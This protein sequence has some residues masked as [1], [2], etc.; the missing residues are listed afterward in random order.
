MNKTILDISNLHLT[1][2]SG[3]S[4]ILKDISF[5]LSQWEVLSVIWKNGTGKSSLLKAI[6]WIQAIASW[7]IEKH[8]KKISYVPQ[9]IH[10]EESFPVKVEEFFKIFNTGVSKNSIIE[11]LKLFD[12]L[13]LSGRN[14]HSLSGWEF[15]KILIINA[16]LSQPELLL[17]DE[18]T[19]GIDM[20]GE[21][22]FY[23]NIALIKEKYPKIAIIL[24]SHNLH[25][26]YKN[27]TRVIC[28]HENNLCC[29]GSPSEILENE[30]INTVFGSYLSPYHHSP[31]NQHHHT[32]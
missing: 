4:Y 3:K 29:H 20:I 21:E 31:H 14:I 6:A 12:V 26:V 10:M 30:D 25:L 5:S 19:S 32:H 7:K 9:K 27:S 8:T 15:Q 17:L 18:P 16:L 22:Q 28:L 13:K 2:N 23:K 11:A 1:Y 24:V